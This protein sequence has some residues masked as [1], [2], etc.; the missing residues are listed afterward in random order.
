MFTYIPCLLHCS[1]ATIKKHVLLAG[2]LAGCDR[3]AQGAELACRL[4]GGLAGC[5][6]A[7][8]LAGAGLP[9]DA[10]LRNRTVSQVPRTAELAQNITNSFVTS[11]GMLEN[12]A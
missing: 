6:R 3:L 2:W 12:S 5:W 10:A 7:G 8:M 4:A 9:A 11:P 1:T